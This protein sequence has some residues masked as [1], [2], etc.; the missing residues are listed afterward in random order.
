MDIKI[1]LAVGVLVLALLGAGAA[2]VS[3]N[4]TL[5]A[6]AKAAQAELSVTKNALK[7]LGKEK[8]K[9]DEQLLED[10]CRRNAC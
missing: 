1:M 7:F 4:A 6:Q 8:V 5:R 9:D 2:L 3:K 10:Y